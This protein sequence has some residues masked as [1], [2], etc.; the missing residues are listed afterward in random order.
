[1]GGGILGHL[2]HLLVNLSCF[3]QGCLCATGINDIIT[4]G[5]VVLLQ[6][7]HTNLYNIYFISTKAIEQL[8][9]DCNFQI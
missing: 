6:N 7:T 5:S 2:L 4:L 3:Q 8:D 1:M 9:L